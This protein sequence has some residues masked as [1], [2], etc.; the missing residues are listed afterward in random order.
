MMGYELNVYI[1]TFADLN[2]R[3]D[4]LFRVELETETE[5]EVNEVVDVEPLQEG[6]IIYILFFHFKAP[7]QSVFTFSIQILSLC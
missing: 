1:K 2:F 3:N 4:F 7:N 6:K 5:F